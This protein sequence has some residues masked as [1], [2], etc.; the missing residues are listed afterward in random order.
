M[1]RR[2]PRSTRTDPL[3]PDTTLFRSRIGQHEAVGR[4]LQPD[5]PTA[6]IPFTAEDAPPYGLIG[7]H[8]LTRPPHSPH[9]RTS[10]RARP[11]FNGC[12]LLTTGPIR[13]ARRHG[14]PCRRAPFLSTAGAPLYPSSYVGHRVRYIVVTPFRSLC[15]T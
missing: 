3:L 7:R 14:R 13:P 10:A 6:F 15:W 9:L 8:P 5:Q 4:K 2:P 12:L 11:S 1:I